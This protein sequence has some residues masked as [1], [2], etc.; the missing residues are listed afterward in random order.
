M[1]S[2]II[3]MAL[4]LAMAS[5]TALALPLEGS[6]ENATVVIFGSS[7]T[8]VE[9]ENVTLEILKVD[10]GLMGAENASYEL[11]D[12]NN[13]V[14]TPGLYRALSSGK[15]AVY[16]LTEWDSLFKLINVTP[17][18]SDPILINWWMTPNASNERIKIRYYGITDSSINSDEQMLVLQVSVENLGGQSIYLTPFNFTLFDQWGWPYQP[19][20]GF[21]AETLAPSSGT[22]RL[23]LGFTGL[24]PVFRPAALAFDYGTPEEMVIDFENGYVPLSDELVY[25]NISASDATANDT[26]ARTKVAPAAPA[27]QTA[28]QTEEAAAAEQPPASEATAKISNIKQMVA[29]SE[30]RLAATREGLDQV[31]QDS[32]DTS[33]SAEALNNSTAAL[34]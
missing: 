29:A 31:N 9:D 33:L 22:D 14:Y 8:P 28:N 12:Q 16:F 20:L 25:G 1:R 30:A 18:G 26:S 15:Q 23:L 27:V 11:V 10:V 6:N 21:D 17:E 34:L 13:L 5:E 32:N 4:L 7:R 2:I 24:S 19:T 3:L